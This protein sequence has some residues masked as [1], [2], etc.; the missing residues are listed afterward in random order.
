MSILD[1]T[2]MT[3]YTGWWWWVVVLKPVYCKTLLIMIPGAPCWH[4]GELGVCGDGWFNLLH[5]DYPTNNRCAASP[6]L[7]VQSVR[8]GLVEAA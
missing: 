6:S 7:R 1:A 3:K 2:K 8:P 5:T 4:A